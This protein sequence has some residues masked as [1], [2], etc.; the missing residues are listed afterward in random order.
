MTPHL[1]TEIQDIINKS[2]P[3][4]VG[5]LL[6]QRLI[7]A[8][9]TEE[10]LRGAVNSIESL[11]AENARLT[12]ENLEA[13]DILKREGE[14]RGGEAQLAAAQTKLALDQAVLAVRAEMTKEMQIQN[15][16][17][18]KA[19]FQNNVF[20]YTRNL[21]EGHAFPVPPSPGNQFP[22]PQTAVTQTTEHVDG[23]G[24]PAAMGPR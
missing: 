5:D 12:K 17:V 2:L 7:A 4:Q 20:K 19:V 24:S 16:E 22:C 3:A 9:Q 15:L 8:D 1:T 11:R 6:K 13:R 14:L 21:Q 23:E 18:V 10:R